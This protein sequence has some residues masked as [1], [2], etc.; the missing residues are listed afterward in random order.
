LIYCHHGYQTEDILAALGMTWADLFSSPQGLHRNGD[1]RGSPHPSQRGA[2]RGWSSEEAAFD[3]LR[4]KA[5]IPKVE[6]AGL[7]VRF[8]D[9]A[10]CL[11]WPGVDA[12]LVRRGPTDN[13]S[14]E[15]GDA[16]GRRP[17]LW[18]LPLFP[19]RTI[20]LTEGA[21]DC[22][23]L[24]A[25]GLPA[26]ASVKGA[27][28][29]LGRVLLALKEAGVEE[30]V[31]AF[32][33]DGAGRAGAEKAAKAAEAAG[34]RVRTLELP[35]SLALVGGKDV[36]DWLATLGGD[37]TRLREAVEQAMEAPTEGQNLTSNYIPQAVGG[38]VANAAD[39]RAQAP[40]ELPWLP[41]LGHEGFIWRG[42][43]VLLSAYPKTG[44]ST[45]VAW[46]AWEWAGAG[47]RVHILSEESLDIWRR[48]LA[49]MP[50]GPWE[51]VSVQPALGLGN[52]G[53]C[54]VVRDTDADIVVVDTWKKVAPLRSF[55]D[56]AEVNAAFAQLLAAQHEAQA[57]RGSPLTLVLTHH[58]RKS[59]E[60]EDEG[61]R[62]ADSHVIFGSVDTILE[63]VRDEGSRR[64]LRGWGR[65][66]E[67]PTVV[68]ERQQEDGRLVVLGSPQEVALAEVKEK[69]L[70][71]L[72]EA[73]D[74]LKTKAVREV[75]PAPRPS[76]E[77]VRRALWELAREG[78]VERRPPLSEGQ[79]PGVTYEWRLPPSG[80]DGPNLTSNGPGYIVGGEVGQA[81]DR[82]PPDSLSTLG[83]TADPPQAEGFE[84]EPEAP[85]SNAHPPI[86]LADYAHQLLDELYGP[87]WPRVLREA[88]ICAWREWGLEDEEPS[89]CPRCRSPD[90]GL[91]I[92]GPE[93]GRVVCLSCR[94]SFQQ[95][96][97]WP[98]PTGPGGA[99]GHD[100]RRCRRCRPSPT[101]SLEVEP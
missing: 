23:A 18:P 54:Q 101:L 64:L 95:P 25:A 97:P 46:L 51:R 19:T 72:A 75:L 76:E 28:R 49:E 32:D 86:R 56:T 48:R 1:H 68:I 11:T 89:A 87:A 31:V 88:A 2:E 6:A 37:P 34:L 71:A 29:D 73:G 83:A 52:E 96:L 36:C 61:Q 41:L 22:L 10:L 90:V 21:T 42:S 47:L 5:G 92:E 39:L 59:S 77:Q 14:W 99:D 38:E 45:L 67:P 85:R 35:Q 60:G 98:P 20:Y 74:W 55:R 7:G 17:D 44:K 69:V 15:A 53:L 93:A 40:R 65:L 80:N 78:R 81:R 62:V 26:Y 8:Q 30:V 27:A 16:E 33:L 12:R 79:R 50:D 63:M 82:P 84:P 94:R 3:W 9:G 66:Q 100:P 43:V 70:A 57:R 58:D 24:R 13:W 4:R 91:V